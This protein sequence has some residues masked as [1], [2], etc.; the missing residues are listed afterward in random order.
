MPNVRLMNGMDYQRSKHVD[1]SI[2]KSRKIRVSARYC[3]K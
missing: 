1:T 3:R 2:F